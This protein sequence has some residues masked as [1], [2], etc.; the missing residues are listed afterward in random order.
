MSK[1]KFLIIIVVSLFILFSLIVFIW[2]HIKNKGN[3]KLA[4]RLYE[5]LID[6]VITQYLNT[7]YDYLSIYVDN[8]VDPLNKK[9][10]SDESKKE[11]LEYSKKYS[12]SVYDM[13]LNDLF[14]SEK[15]KDSNLTG[16]CISFNFNLL[17][18]GEAYINVYSYLDNQAAKVQTYMVKYSKNNW[19]ISK[20]NTEILS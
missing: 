11:I 20:I 19:N 3:E 14:T 4:T 6:S 10:L 5:D 18:Y 8:I 15:F 17:D 1:K 12:N 2:L 9:L 13:R 16:I 7:S